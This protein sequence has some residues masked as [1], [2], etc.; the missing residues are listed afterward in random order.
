MKYINI[1]N[2]ARFHIIEHRITLQLTI[3]I[4]ILSWSIK[5]LHASQ[6]LSHE[7]MVCFMGTDKSIIIY[8]R[9]I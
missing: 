6:I 9:D 1:L 4:F 8:L 2:H 5:I 7:P 3:I